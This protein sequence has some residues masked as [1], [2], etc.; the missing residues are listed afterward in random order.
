MAEPLFSP[1]QQAAISK[2]ASLAEVKK[3]IMT[4]SAMDVNLF[5]ALLLKELMQTKL[6]DEYDVALGMS[7]VDN[8]ILAFWNKWTQML[9]FWLTRFVA[10]TLL[11][12]SGGGWQQE[13]MVTDITKNLHEI[14]EAAKKGGGK[15]LEAPE[16]RGV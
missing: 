16:V 14:I 9:S 1:S 10:W 12:R 13:M 6:D 2:A 7:Y 15:Q 4:I 5:R 8:C 3:E 11:K